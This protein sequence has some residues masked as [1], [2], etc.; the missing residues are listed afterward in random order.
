MRLMFLIFILFGVYGS[1]WR[2]AQG[3][4]VAPMPVVVYPAY[5][6]YVPAQQVIY[7]PYVQM[8]P[9]QYQG[10]SVHQIQYPTPLRDLLFGKYR[11]DHYY[12]PQMNQVQR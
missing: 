5:P 7:R 4:V 11:I 6:V 3:Q 9:Y 10:S 1:N 12:A 8:V 2:I